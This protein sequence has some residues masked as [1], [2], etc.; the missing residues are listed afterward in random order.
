MVSVPAGLAAF[1]DEIGLCAEYIA[2][3]R[4]ADIVQLTEM[5]K[6]GHFAAFEQPALLAADI[7]NFVRKVHN[8]KI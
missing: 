2:K 7:Q 5:P 6:G 1:P 8:R 3:L 4:F